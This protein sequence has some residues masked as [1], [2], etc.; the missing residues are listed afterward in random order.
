MQIES[1]GCECP[2]A[3]DDEVRDHTICGR[4]GNYNS[5]WH[6]PPTPV[7]ERLSRLEKRMDKLD[8]N[9]TGISGETAQ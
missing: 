4:F 6:N 8:G 7:E 5:T 1:V 2:P 9:R 3:M